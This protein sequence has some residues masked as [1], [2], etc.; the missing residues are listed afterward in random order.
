MSPHV[1]RYR[2]STWYPAVLCVQDESF[3]V[4]LHL[5]CIYGHADVATL[6]L[7]WGATP[8]A[9]DN[10]GGCPP[11]GDGLLVYVC[12]LYCVTNT[13]HWHACH[14][15]RSAL[16]IA[17]THRGPGEACSSYLKQPCGSLAPAALYLCH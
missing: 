9:W 10:N 17:P 3:Q 6:L 8:W 16:P 7:Q 1:S 11:G 12:R 14:F 4:P 13:Q 2:H 15:R 5:A